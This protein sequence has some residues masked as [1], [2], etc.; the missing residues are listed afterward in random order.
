MKWL[1]TVSFTQ[2][3]EKELTIYAQDEESASEKAAAIVMKWDDVI[4]AE[5]VDVSEVEDG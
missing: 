1:V 5:A 2:R 4:D 3:R